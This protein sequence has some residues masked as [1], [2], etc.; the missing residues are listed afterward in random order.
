MGLPDHARV[1][2][3]G[4]G[5]RGIRKYVRLARQIDNHNPDVLVFQARAVAYV[6]GRHEEAMALIQRALALNPN[7]AGACS[8]AGWIYVYAGQPETAL[9]HLQRAIRLNPR[10][11]GDFHTWAPLAHAFMQLGRDGE[12]IEAARQAAQRGPNYIAAW[13]VLSAILALSGKLE[14]AQAAMATLLRLAPNMSLTRMKSMPTW[15]AAAR[16][17][18]FEGLRLAG[19]PE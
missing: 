14:E 1:V 5:R 7:S 11:P 13:R 15:T 6:D 19:M 18:Y 4:R 10:D 17:R 12:A 9:A 3:G 2:H 8:M 16:A